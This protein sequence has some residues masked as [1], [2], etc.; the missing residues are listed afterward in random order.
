MP[1]APSARLSI[2]SSISHAKH[3]FV[4]GDNCSEY[5]EESE[6]GRGPEGRIGFLFLPTDGQTVLCACT[7]I[8]YSGHQF[9]LIVGL[10]R[11][12]KSRSSSLPS[13]PPLLLR[14][15]INHACSYNIY[16]TSLLLSLSLSL[17]VVRTLEGEKPTLLS[18]TPDG[19]M[20]G[21]TDHRRDGGGAAAIVRPVCLALP[22]AARA[23]R[24]AV[25]G[26][27]SIRV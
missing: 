6:P 13:P 9:A 26:V 3:A 27:L 19:R 23:E 25:Q 15:S 5:Q 11:S 1:I 16:T 24:R 7:P 22:A 4:L 10:F 14:V 17:V 20:D 12:K 8:F 2:Y 21:R 18:F